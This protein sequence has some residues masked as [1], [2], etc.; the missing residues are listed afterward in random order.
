MT[1]ATRVCA[2]LTRLEGSHQHSHSLSHRLTLQMLR[3]GVCSK[4]GSGRDLACA[5]CE[6]ARE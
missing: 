3:V 2:F 4:T 1:K 6:R 5:M